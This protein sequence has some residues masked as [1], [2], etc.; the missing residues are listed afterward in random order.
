VPHR[1][2]PTRREASTAGRSEAPHRRVLPRTK[3]V[4]PINAVTGR[5]FSFAC[6]GE[7]P[8]K[9]SRK[10]FK[11]NGLQLQT[12]SGGVA[13]QLFTLTSPPSH[14]TSI[15]PHLHLTSISTVGGI[16]GVLWTPDGAVGARPLI[17]SGSRAV[18]VPRGRPRSHPVGRQHKLLAAGHARV[19]HPGRGSAPWSM[20][21]LCPRW[22]R[23]G[24]CRDGRW[25]RAASLAVVGS[26]PPCRRAVW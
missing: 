1:T 21:T 19:G 14:L 18:S 5:G 15:S 24:V 2:T 22:F 17:L 6:P 23:G 3:E 26:S 8:Q 13:Q 11:C 20:A 16:S 4:R 12:S 25:C 10:G 9:A 7:R